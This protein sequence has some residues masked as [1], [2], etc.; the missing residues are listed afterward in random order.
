M[1]K[2]KGMEGKGEGRERGKGREREGE[3]GEGWPAPPFAN[4]WI[5]P[6]THIYMVIKRSFRFISHFKFCLKIS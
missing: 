3:G 2:G 5:R 1:G 4:F 6:W